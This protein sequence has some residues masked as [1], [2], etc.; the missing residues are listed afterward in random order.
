MFSSSF[1][2]IKSL[3][4]STQPY[5]TQ[6]AKAT[7]KSAQHKLKYSP[8]PHDDRHIPLWLDGTLQKALHPNPFKRYRE[9]SEFLYDL[10]HPNKV[11]TGQSRPPLIERDPVVFWKGVSFVLIIIIGI[12]LSRPI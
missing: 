10:R 2:L 7:T 8:I 5:G 6:V 1:L 12:L 4:T 3:A 11:F 9:L